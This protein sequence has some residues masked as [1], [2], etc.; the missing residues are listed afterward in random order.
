MNGT[1]LTTKQ[2]VILLAAAFAEFVWIGLPG[3]MIT[4]ASG[5]IGMSLDGA[6]G[7]QYGFFLMLALAVAV[8]LLWSPTALKISAPLVKKLAKHIGAT[9]DKEE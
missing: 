9:R 7:K 3:Y 5:A 6:L 1:E 8:T 4:I 2:I